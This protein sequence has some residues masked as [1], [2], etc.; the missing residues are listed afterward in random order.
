MGAWPVARDVKKVFF[1]GLLLWNALVGAD[2][3]MLL[4]ILDVSLNGC[5]STKAI[6]ESDERLALS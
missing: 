6:L 5:R 1:A 2:L 3:T 4:E